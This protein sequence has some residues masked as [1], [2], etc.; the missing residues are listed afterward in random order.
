MAAPKKWDKVKGYEMWKAGKSD[1]EI[2]EAV[3]VTSSAVNVHRRKHWDGA[4][5]VPL[6]GA[7][8]LRLWVRTL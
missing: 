2:A 3:G 6:G 8:M 1:K 7:R 4:G 5:R